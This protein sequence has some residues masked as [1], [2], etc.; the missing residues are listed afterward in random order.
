MGNYFRPSAPFTGGTVSGDTYFLQNLSARTYYSAS[1]PLD[2]IIDNIASK[3]SAEGEFVHLSGDTM[4]GQLLLPSLSANTITGTTISGVDVYSNSI[5]GDILFSG[6]TNLYDIFATI[7]ETN[8]LQNEIN[9]LSGGTSAFTPTSNFNSFTSLTQSQLNT[10]SNLSGATFIGQVNIPTLSATTYLGLPIDVYTT[11]GTY[12]P[13]TGVIVFNNNTGG[14]YTVGGFFK[15]SDDIFTTGLTFN[16]TNYDLTLYK[17]DGTSYSQS[18]AILAT[19]VIVTGGTYNPNTGVATFYNNSGGTFQVSGFLTGQT[20]THV[21]GLTFNNNILTLKQTNNQTNLDVNINN[22]S[23]LTVNGNFSA[24]TIYS[25]NTNLID[26]FA[27]IIHSHNQYATLS[28][29]TFTGEINTPSLSATTLSADTYFSGLTPL[30][31]IINNIASQYSG[32]TGDFLS[33]SGG[34]VTGSTQFT[35]GLT[36]NTI[37]ATTYFGLPQDIFVTGATKSGTVAI[38]TNNSGG[39][40]N[41]TGLTDTFVTG[42]TYSSS[43]STLTLNRN[44]GGSVII[45]GITAGST[46]GTVSGNYLPLSGGS[47]TGALFAPSISATTFSGNSFYF[48]TGAT[49]TS[50]VGKLKWNDIDGTLDLGL[51]GGN[52]TLQIGQEQ[53]ARV[54]NKTGSDL[55]ESEYK[56][57]RISG[58][59]G[60]RLG[61][62]LAQADSN[63]NA[64]GTLGIVTENIDKNQEGFITT[65]GR[66]NEINTTGSLQGETWNDGDILYLSPTIPGNLTKVKPLAPNHSVVVA[67]VEYAHSQHGKLFVKVDNGYEL[68][69]LHNVNVS[70]ATSGQLLQYNGILWVNSNP[71]S[72]Y[73]Q[74]SVFSTYTASTLNQLNS[75]ASLSGA[76][77]TDSVSAPSISATTY[78]GLPTDIYTTGAT[79]S[80]TVATFI[81]NTGGTFT[82]TGLTDTFTTGGTYSSG[83]LTFNNNTGGTY[84]VT[85]L[86]RGFESLDLDYGDYIVSGNTNENIVKTVLIPANTVRSNNTLEIASR[87]LR[88][89]G[90]SGNI[91]AK[92]RISTSS[93]PSPVT[94]ATQL[95]QFTVIGTTNNWLQG[96]RHITVKNATSAT[97]MFNST[98]QAASDEVVVTNQQTTLAID[99][100][101][102]QYLFVTIQNANSTD[103]SSLSYSEIILIK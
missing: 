9:Q 75:K 44:D 85:G 83:M 78:L 80:G 30:T 21:T 69:D 23:G 16:Q 8:Y 64:S 59:Q 57:V 66:V 95:A 12:N 33:L 93:S 41:L 70:G 79:K 100:T 13:N 81:N 31:T 97:T 45:T 1:T 22:F 98:I 68:G 89:S 92:L 10:K 37:S 29:A 62:V 103:T 25:G 51:K 26:I 32:V 56:V 50:Q 34:T 7:G 38:F 73:T 2:I 14:T 74:N 3:Y 60:Q 20:D 72:S 101:V 49:E 35:N 15:P 46:G 58:A 11:G 88:V 27:P 18:L 17:N 55:L 53:L 52:V 42:G 47:L 4:F 43:T 28:G 87:I 24:T 19:D 65:F 54:V 76:A 6:N 82:L 71:L 77:F 40:F 84:T 86:P 91:N 90:N 61:V 39:T 94:T 67:F 99:W 48:N 36:A 102:N 96:K 5:S 63:A